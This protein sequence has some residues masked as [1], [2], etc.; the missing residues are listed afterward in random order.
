MSNQIACEIFPGKPVFRTN[1]ADAHIFGLEPNFGCCT[2][3]FGQGWPKFALSAFLHRGDTVVSAVPVPSELTDG[4]IHI[5]LETDYP[6]ENR[7]V[8]TVETDR[9]FTLVVRAPSFA[10]NLTV[11]GEAPSGELRFSFRAGDRRTLELRFGVTPRFASRPHGLSAVRC[12]SL[13]FSVPIAYEKRVHEYVRDGVERKAPY[14]DY[15][16]LPR[17]DWNYAYC[18]SLSAPARKAVGKVPFSSE[19]PPVVLRASV[20]KIGWGYE[21]GYETVCAKVP[22]CVVPVSE[23]EEVLL[24][25]YGCA[26]LRMTELPVVDG[27]KP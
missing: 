12:G 25:P 23:P 18:G 7:L 15:E 4:G 11:N 17:S 26:K 2:A 6:F 16:Y 27:I 1:G 8:Y 22:H 14:C 19:A 5:V 13:V 3:N 20:R 10:E 9:P 21:D 24:Y